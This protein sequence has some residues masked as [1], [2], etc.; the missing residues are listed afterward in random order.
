MKRINDDLKSSI[1]SELKVFETLQE[2]YDEYSSV[3][4]VHLENFRRI[5]VYYAGLLIVVF[6]TFIV[7]KIY[8]YIKRNLIRIKYLYF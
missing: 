3:S 1:K 8:K 7:H 6:F 4:G 2:Y 5:F